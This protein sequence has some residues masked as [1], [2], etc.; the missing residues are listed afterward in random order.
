MFDHHGREAARFSMTFMAWRLENWE[1]CRA[2]FEKIAR[3][4][5]VAAEVIER[6]GP[7]PTGLVHWALGDTP[8]SVGLSHFCQ[9]TAPGG[10]VNR[11]RIHASMVKAI[12]LLRVVA[13]FCSRLC[14]R[15]LRPCDA[16]KVG[17]VVYSSG[18]IRVMSVK[19]DNLRCACP[20]EGI[21]IPPP[22]APLSIERS[23]LASL[24]A[25]EDEDDDIASF[26]D[27][28]DVEINSTHEAAAVMAAMDEDDGDDDVEI[29]REIPREEEAQWRASLTGRQ[30][31]Q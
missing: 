13:A 18:L 22:R 16:I 3:G 17:Y 7:D 2:P 15:R 25:L 31:V 1:R 24:Q 21:A 29:V 14:Y 9:C 5:V 23:M 20:A 4:D 6:F 12:A 8:V 26:S 19:G 28:D 30:L 10:S 27:D 11:C